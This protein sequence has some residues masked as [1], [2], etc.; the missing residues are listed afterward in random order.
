MAMIKSFRELEVYKLGLVQAARIFAVPK[1]FPSEERYSLTDQNPAFAIVA[2]GS[3][4]KK[5]IKFDCG[6][7]R[8]NEGGP[9]G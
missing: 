4:E 6:S 1:S 5:E 9:G 2:E 3:C 7:P 8:P